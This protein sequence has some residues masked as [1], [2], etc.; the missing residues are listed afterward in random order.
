MIS[1]CPVLTYYHK[2]LDNNKIEKWIKYYFY[3]V[4]EHGQNGATVNEGYTTN[5]KVEIIIP[6]E[7]VKDKSIFANGDILLIGKGNDIT[8]QKDLQGKEFYNVI[9][10]EVDDYGTR[11]HVYLGGQ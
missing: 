9:Q 10:W 5:N 11:P 4:W 6:I 2:T 3:D 1:N 7:K 8:M